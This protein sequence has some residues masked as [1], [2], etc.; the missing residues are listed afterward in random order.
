L[1]YVN[2]L[3][4]EGHTTKDAMVERYVASMDRWP[5][6]LATDLV[7]R[8]ANSAIES[9]AESRTFHLCW[10]QRLPI[11]VPQ[12]VVL[13]NDVIVARLDFAWPEL[14]AWLE[15]DGLVKYA[16]LVAQGETASDVVIREKKREDLV[17]ELTG[18]RC[19]RITWADLYQPE[20]TALRIRRVL[21]PPVAA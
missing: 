21:F 8:L 18:W 19:I 12:Y 7:I 1:S 2:H 14:G 5:N 15:F 11:P 17:R 20:A 9:V 10:R 16:G 4:H 6:S 3:L 13:D